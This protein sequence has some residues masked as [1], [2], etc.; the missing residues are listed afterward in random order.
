MWSIDC[1]LTGHRTETYRSY[2][3]CNAPL[4]LLDKSL[5]R[6]TNLIVTEIS[7]LGRYY[8]SILFTYNQEFRRDHP[9]TSRRDAQLAHL[10]QV[11]EEYDV[12]PYRIVYIGKDKNETRTYVAA[13]AAI[14]EKYLTMIQV[15]VGS[16]W[17]SDNGKEFFPKGESVLEPKGVN[18][19]SYPAPV[20]QYLSGNDNN[21]HSSAAATWRGMRLDY[22]DDVKASIALLHCL[23]CDGVNI[24]GYFANNLQIGKDTPS[25]EK[26]CELIGGKDILSNSMMKQCMYEYCVAFK[27]DGRGNSDEV[28]QDDLDGIYWQ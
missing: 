10:D 28:Y 16:T 6:F 9:S 2:A 15:D 25:E 23:D 17:L 8:H 24:V 12:A 21:H 27:K 3:Q 7:S 26:V 19:V 18:H 22:S 13:S 11:L 20:H 14:I 4:P 1:K 5:S